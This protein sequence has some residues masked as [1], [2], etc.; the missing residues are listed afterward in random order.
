ML[1]VRLSGPGDARAEKV[2]SKDIPELNRIIDGKLAARS[3]DGGGNAEQAAKLIQ[4]AED[5]ER[6][7]QFAEAAKK[8]D[9]ARKIDPRSYVATRGYARLVK[10]V[11]KKDVI[12]KAIRAYCDAITLKPQ[13]LENYL[14]AAR[15]ARES[16]QEF[17]IQAVEILNHAIAHHPQ[18][19]NALDLL[20]SALR[21]TGNGKLSKAWDEYRSEIVKR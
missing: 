4:E 2:R 9:A 19:T 8:Y 1:F 7:K 18:D 21:K 12:R 10:S 14:E 13:S 15:L 11:E 17:R 16:D 5:L 20:I 6:K 3:G